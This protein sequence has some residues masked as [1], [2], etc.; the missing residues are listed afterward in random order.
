MKRNEVLIYASMWIN[1]G[2]I[3]LN[4]RSQ[5]Q[6]TTSLYEMSRTGSSIDIE[7]ELVVT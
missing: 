2:H 1:L 6:K 4:K 5:S 3:M 7:S